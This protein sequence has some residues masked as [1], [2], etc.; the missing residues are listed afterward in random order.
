M[1]IYTYICNWGSRASGRAS[2]LHS[3]GHRFDAFS[4]PIL[5]EH[6]YESRNR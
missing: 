6:R 4:L 2:D 3:E 5:K 1:S